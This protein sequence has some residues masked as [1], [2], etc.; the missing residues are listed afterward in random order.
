MSYYADTGFLLSL[1]LRE[2]TS[3]AATSSMS[4]IHDP[5]PVT[6]RV[7]IEFR[8]ALRLGV[9]GQKFTEIGR[10]VNET[11]IPTLWGKLSNCK[12]N[13]SDLKGANWLLKIISRF[14]G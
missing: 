2:S 1:H 8:N 5:L 12:R 4:H 7:A 9:F 11:F 14:Y 6:R 13:K 10:C 3:Q